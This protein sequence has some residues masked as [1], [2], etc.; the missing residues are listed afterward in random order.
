MCNGTLLCRNFCQMTL[1]CP[2]TAIRRMSLWKIY[3]RIG[4]STALIIHTKT[5][6]HIHH[7]GLDYLRKYTCVGLIA[8]WC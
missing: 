5:A 3:Y 7:L 2:K 4:E 1:P 6:T 8:Y